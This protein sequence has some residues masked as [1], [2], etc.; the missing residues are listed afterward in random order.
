MLSGCV[1][2]EPMEFGV[3]FTVEGILLH[4]GNTGK[5]R[6]ASVAPRAEVQLRLS[7]PVTRV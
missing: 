7:L 2:Q 1:C 3:S 6:T 5:G 4:K